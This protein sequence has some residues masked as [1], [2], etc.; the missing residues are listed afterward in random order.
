MFISKWTLRK[1]LTTAGRSAELWSIPLSGRGSLDKDC[2]LKWYKTETKRTWSFV[3]LGRGIWNVFCCC[4]STHSY[5]NLSVCNPTSALPGNCNRSSLVQTGPLVITA[6]KQRLKEDTAG[7]GRAI[8]QETAPCHMCLFSWDLKHSILCIIHDLEIICFTSSNTFTYFLDQ[9]RGRFSLGGISKSGM[10]QREGKKGHLTYAGTS[11][12]ASYL[13]TLSSFNR[14]W[15]S[16][17]S[18]CFDRIKLSRKFSLVKTHRLLP[19][20]HPKAV[21]G[22]ERSP[23]Q[24]KSKSQQKQLL[25]QDRRGPSSSLQHESLPKGTQG[26]WN[27]SV[28]RVSGITVSE[29]LH[30]F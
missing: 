3:C 16:T 11:G 29:K 20:K 14:D 25:A 12:G 2:F 26:P 10:C 23:P 4:C 19:H 17:G 5:T 13:S 22:I 27:H 6:H 7:A 28:F 15:V 21:H 18:I 8:L 1:T 30:C 24:G 9:V